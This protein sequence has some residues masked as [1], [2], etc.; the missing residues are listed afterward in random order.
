MRKRA[1]TKNRPTP[2][3]TKEI[4]GLSGTAGTC[5]A[6]TWRSGSAT[7]MSTPITS[8]VIINNFRFLERVS[9]AP[10]RSPMGIMDRSA[11]RENRHIPTIS[12]TSPTKKEPN[13]PPGMGAMVK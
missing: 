5:R 13:V 6:S 8:A 7:V 10:I 2:A 11:P 3:A 12:K 9:C 4:S 1:A